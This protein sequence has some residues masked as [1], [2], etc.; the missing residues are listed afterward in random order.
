ME[1][2]PE[3]PLRIGTRRS[4]LALAQAEMV[5]GALLIVLELDEGSIVLVPMLASGDK[6]TDRP[7]A[8]IGGKALWTKELERAL[9]ED[10]VDVAVHSMRSEERRVGKEC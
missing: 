3:K 10:I 2:T 1:Y 6:I 8:E 5:A 4:P 9:V 7:L